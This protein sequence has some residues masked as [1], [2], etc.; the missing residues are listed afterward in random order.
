MNRHSIR[1]RLLITM[2]SLVITLLTT[3][4]YVQ[5]RS[6]QEIL[7]KEL[8][9][10]ETLMREKTLQRGKTLS[11]NL[12]HQVAIEMAALNLSKIAE[13]IQASV[14]EN[15]EL[16][17]GILMDIDRMVLI[18]TQQPLLES[19]IISAPEDFFAV[20]QDYPTQQVIEKNSEEI[21][22]FITP[23]QVSTQPWGVLRLGFSMTKVASEIAQFHREIDE[24]NRTMVIQSIITA[25]IFLLFGSPMVFMISTEISRPLVELTDAARQIAT[26]NF[27]TKIPVQV[28]SQDEVSLLATAFADMTRNLEYSY[29]KLEQ[30][31]KAYERFVPR[32]FLSLLDKQSVIDIELGDQVEREMTV[33]FADIRG[34]TALS[35]RMTPQENFRFINSY[36]SQMVPIIEQNHGFIDKYI[37]DA[38]M[39]L[40]P[41]GADDAVRGAIAMLET[42]VKYNQGRQRAGYPQISIGIGINSGPLML[43]TVGSHNRMDGTV[44][45]DAVNLASRIEGLTKNYGTPL[46]ITEP[47]YQK[48]TDVSQYHIRLIDC[49][50][51]KGKTE[52]VKVYEVFDADK[53]NIIELKTKTLHDF[54]RGFE[55]FHHEE[56][57]KAWDTF[58]KV[59]RINQNDKVAQIYLNHCQRVLGM[60]RSEVPKIL[61]VD[62]TTIN[63]KLLSTL[64]SRNNFEVIVANS[65]KKALELV[66]IEH[67]HLILLDIVMPETDGFET[68]RQLKA[69][70]SFQNIPVIFITGLSEV[71]N[72]IKG[73]EVGAVDYITKPFQREEV[74][75]RIKTHLSILRLQQKVLAKDV[76]LNINNLKLKEKI[77]EMVQGKFFD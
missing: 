40:F 4:T 61:V 13:L 75:A 35:E 7:E 67:P 23:I 63:L 36:L 19:E 6:Q 58:H 52:L 53:P 62:D 48:L 29:N 73:F 3:L 10:R 30:Y 66:E 21:V 44:I 24:Q 5:I 59:S 70:L 77:N 64:L 1:W 43:G 26:G 38:I 45:S 68:C 22:E 20:A 72:K 9:R 54:E 47:T 41:D 28:K 16:V 14:K 39:A 57:E 50:T 18:H 74:L 69:R 56:F 46:L 60:I 42:L 8:V 55:Y 15:P 37:G 34:F 31:N 27:A 76:D 2:L 11:D 17:Y 65:G 71:E 33:L 49:V 32:K 51:V 12:A 25:I